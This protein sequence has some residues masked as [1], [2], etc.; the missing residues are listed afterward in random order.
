M[1]PNTGS[2]PPRW[3]TIAWLVG[4]FAS[5]ALLAGSPPLIVQALREREA[6]RIHDFYAD[7]LSPC[8]P[9]SFQDIDA[10]LRRLLPAEPDLIVTI[11][12]A[13]DRP[14]ALAFVSNDVHLFAFGSPGENMMP[15][16]PEDAFAVKARRITAITP[17]LARSITDTLALDIEHAHAESPLELDG[18]A[19]YFRTAD[20]TCAT[21]WSPMPKTRAG[22]WVS[23]FHSL[24]QD[25]AADA[26]PLDPS[27]EQALSQQIEALRTQG[28]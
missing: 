1:R 14:K 23:L 22:A 15:D 3:R 24:A 5:V 2:G 12:A 16:A 25:I 10:A 11:S 21:A 26:G 19:Y 17:A 28:P 6:R 8:S 9:L 7:G 27:A 20:G 18:T 13:F 4:L